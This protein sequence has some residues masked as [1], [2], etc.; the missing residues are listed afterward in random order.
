MIYLRNAK[1]IYTFRPVYSFVT[2]VSSKKYHTGPGMLNFCLISARVI[3][4][5]FTI[6]FDSNSNTA[7][8][9]Q[10][11]SIKNRHQLQPYATEKTTTL[12]SVSVFVY[13]RWDGRK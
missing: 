1:A 4:V 13:Q 12:L 5:T 10:F 6:Q 11:L 8:L 3:F 7:P 2:Y 9:D